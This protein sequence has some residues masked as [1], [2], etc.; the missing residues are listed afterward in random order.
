[1]TSFRSDQ[2]AII[3]SQLLPYTI[4]SQWGC[5]RLLL[6]DVEFV[7]QV[8]DHAILNTV[9]RWRKELWGDCNCN[10]CTL[11]TPCMSR[12][13]RVACFLRDILINDS[14]G[15]WAVENAT[16]STPRRRRALE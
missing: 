10:A 6:S 2:D 16:S 3:L 13:L 15:V 8:G 9:T 1:M 12:Y 14:I 7:M 11:L 5:S 4:I